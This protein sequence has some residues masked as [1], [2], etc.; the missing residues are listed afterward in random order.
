MPREGKSRGIRDWS[1]AANNCVVP[2]PFGRT[3]ISGRHSVRHF[4]ASPGSG[5]CPSGY[6]PGDTETWP[7]P[8]PNGCY[9]S[10]AAMVIRVDAECSRWPRL[11]SR[12]VRGQAQ[13]RRC[14]REGPGAGFERSA[15]TGSHVDRA[16]HSLVFSEQASLSCRRWQ[17]W[18]GD[19]C[20]ALPW[21]S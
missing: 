15:V 1:C 19:D 13:P 12:F 10:T 8:L 2:R 18:V 4:G 3:T 9:R 20:E 11:G 17:V 7:G 6:I 5:T 21:R 14:G 16:S